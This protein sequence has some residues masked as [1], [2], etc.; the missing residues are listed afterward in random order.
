MTTAPIRTE[1]PTNPYAKAWDIFLDM[2]GDHEL[3]VVQDIGVYRHLRMKAPRTRNWSWDIVTWPDHLATSGD[4]AD[5]YT[6]TCERDMIK[7]FFGKYGPKRDYY[8]DGA[9]AINA[10][11]WAGKLCGGRHQ[12]VKTHSPEKF[13]AEVTENFE[14]MIQD[15]IITEKQAAK[16][17]AEAQGHKNSHYE[18]V[19]WMEDCEV[20][21]PHLFKQEVDRWLDRESV[22]NENQTNPETDRIEQLRSEAQVAMDNEEDAMSWLTRPRASIGPNADACYDS[23]FSDIAHIDLTEYR[24]HFL[25]ACYAINLTVQR[26]LELRRTTSANDD[27][28]VT[29]GRSMENDPALPI[30]DMEPLERLPAH[31]TQKDYLDVEH[32]LQRL[33]ERIIEHTMRTGV[34]MTPGLVEITDQIRA[35]TKEHGDHWA[36]GRLTELDENYAA[37]FKQL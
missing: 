2:T 28:I 13:I 23:A 12:E 5:G 31:A 36:T 24:S 19:T 17:V 20:Y 27:H 25:Y 6:F 34:P 1:K 4:I 35:R 3:V 11:Y 21:W 15:E 10:R 8:S 26:Y 16:L 32:Q 37:H 7:G 29:V 18:A 22:L 9:P 30:F 14:E 33:F